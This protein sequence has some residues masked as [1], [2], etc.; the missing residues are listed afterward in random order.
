MRCSIFSSSAHTH[1]NVGHVVVHIMT[2]DHRD[3]MNL[4]EIWVPAAAAHKIKA[5]DATIDSAIVKI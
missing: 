4:E 2:Q 3:Y 1:S 5:H